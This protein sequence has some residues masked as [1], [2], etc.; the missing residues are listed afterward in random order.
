MDG[1][2]LHPTWVHFVATASAEDQ[3]DFSLLLMTGIKRMAFH[4]TAFP[5]LL[6][7]QNSVM[8]QFP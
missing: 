5:I 3:I 2:S 1:I 6:Y 7:L 8:L 4:G